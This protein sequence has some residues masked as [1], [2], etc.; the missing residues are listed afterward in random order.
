MIMNSQSLD[1]AQ[2]SC[3][4]TPLGGA[5]KGGTNKA[6]LS[7]SVC[8]GL[9]VWQCFYILKTFMGDLNLNKIIE[10]L[11]CLDQYLK[12]GVNI[13]DFWGKS[14]GETIHLSKLARNAG[15]CLQMDDDQYFP[16][17]S[18]PLAQSPPPT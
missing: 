8:D 17:P 12:A 16:M 4:L 15:L 13:E 3:L 11:I 10:I 2:V 6:P 5:N 14:E 9:T 18:P 7:E 1:N